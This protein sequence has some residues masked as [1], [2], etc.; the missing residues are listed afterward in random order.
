M[1]KE[2]RMA[3]AA[4]ALLMAICGSSTAFAQKH[5]GILK[6]YSP[7]SPPSMSIL[8]EA[9]LSSQAPLMGVFNNLV[10]F[11]QHVKQDS[12]KSIVPDLATGWSWNEDGTE[13]TFPLR[14]GVRWH[15][16]KPFTAADVICTWDLLMERSK[17]KLRFNPRKSFYK[18][19]D[20]VTAN[21]D[22]EVTFRLKRPQPA[23]L[24]LLASGFSVIYPCDV[25]PAQMRQHPIGTG[26]FK[27][28]E[29]KPNE[30]I[31]VA[32]NPDYWKP[33]LPYLD[34]IE[35]KI[36]RNPATAVLVFV[37]GQVDMTFPYNLTIPL[38]K[39]LQNQL[40]QA[41]SLSID[42]KAFIDIL[43]EGQDR[44]CTAATA[45]GIMGNA[46]GPPENIDRL[47]I[48]TSNSMKIT[49]VARSATTPAIAALRSTRWS[50]HI[51]A[52]QW[53]K[54]ARRQTIYGRGRQM[55]LGGAARRLDR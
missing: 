3:A 50:A 21:G 55:H 1:S 13:V 40:P 35:Y 9:T 52:A 6:M 51:S 2:V 19:L 24:M 31:K 46:G 42:R 8:E 12:L 11:D 48:P 27:F 20:Q 25:P 30:H 26:P 5:G 36:I 4:S 28:V 45:R 16:G 7:D 17:E 23:F 54:M 14:R 39:D 15:D 18:N 33:D 22:Y 37:S 10:M 38:L 43:T 44:R 29:F 53:R 47:R 32:K 41:I 49:C 34:G